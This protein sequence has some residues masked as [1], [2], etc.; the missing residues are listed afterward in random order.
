MA[1]AQSVLET[2]DRLIENG[3]LK[4]TVD[5]YVD[6]LRVS[7]SS[8]YQQEL[9]RK[10]CESA[11]KLLD[12][13]IRRRSLREF[14]DAIEPIAVGMR[15]IASSAE[16]TGVYS[17]VVNGDSTSSFS[18]VYFDS[19]TVS[20]VVV[21]GLPRHK[22]CGCTQPDGAEV[23]GQ[24][25]TLSLKALL[26]IES[27][28]GNHKLYLVFPMRN[29]SVGVV[30]R[31]FASI[32]IRRDGSV[33]GVDLVSH[34]TTDSFL[35]YKLGIVSADPALRV[36]SSSGGS[37]DDRLGFPGAERYLLEHLPRLCPYLSTIAAH[38]TH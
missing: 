13:V 15:D 17:S 30:E 26:L 37:L 14:S 27:S 16:K 32:S 35:Q 12:D 9:R 33:D 18:P 34:M 8:F 38:Q 23:F 7:P 24:S 5:Q 21:Y 2:L 29:D 31:G 4:S 22:G 36:S 3:E 11:E 19:D 28:G 6:S 25:G 10:G 20:V 1:R